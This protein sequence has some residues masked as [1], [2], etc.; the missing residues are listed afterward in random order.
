MNLSFKSTQMG[1]THDLFM[2]KRVHNLLQRIR[3]VIKQRK[4]MFRIKKQLS[5]RK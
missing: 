4:K 2:S 3:K 1:Y 5:N